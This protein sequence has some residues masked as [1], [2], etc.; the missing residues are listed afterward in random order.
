MT[1]SVVSTLPI[2]TTNMTGFRTRCAGLSLTNESRIARLTI[3][4]SKRGLEEYAMLHQEVLD[5]RAERKRREERQRGDDDDDAE[6]QDDEEWRRHRERPGC[7]G[8]D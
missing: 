3:G 1:T 5:D 8:G 7:L 6:E 2:M 4:G